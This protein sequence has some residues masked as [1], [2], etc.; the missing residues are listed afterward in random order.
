MKVTYFGAT[1]NIRT[2]YLNVAMWNSKS[3][4]IVEL[5][6]ISEFISNDKV[7][8]TQYDTVAILCLASGEYLEWTD[9]PERS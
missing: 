7:Y 9:E 4:N 2:V 5:T 3:N 8:Y 6:R 1:G